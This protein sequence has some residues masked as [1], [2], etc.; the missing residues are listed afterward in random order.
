M[1]VR[2]HCGLY[3]VT[4]V[5]L[6]AKGVPQ[7]LEEAIREAARSTCTSCTHPGATL[8]CVARHCTTVMHVHCARQSNAFVNSENFSMLC[9]RHKNT[10]S[11]KESGSGKMHQQVNPSDTCC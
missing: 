10:G 6:D 3:G 8:A 1:Y 2:L 4:G 9:S 7:G 11:A 5:Y